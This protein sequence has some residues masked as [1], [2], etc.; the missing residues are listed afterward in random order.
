[1]GPSAG[2]I[3]FINDADTID[4]LKQKMKKK[5]IDPT[6]ANFFKDNYENPKALNKARNNFC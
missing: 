4:S 5:N 6:L 1:M 3:E 2:I